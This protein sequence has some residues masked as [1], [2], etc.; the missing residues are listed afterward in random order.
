MR[1]AFPTCAI[2]PSENDIVVRVLIYEVSPFFYTV[3]IDDLDIAI[4]NMEKR[5]ILLKESDF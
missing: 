2:A 3:I 5:I 1:S 4:V